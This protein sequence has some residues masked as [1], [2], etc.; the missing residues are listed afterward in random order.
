MINEV[1]GILTSTKPGG[2]GRNTDRLF[3]AGV[4]EVDAN[5][6]NRPREAGDKMWSESGRRGL[7]NC[8]GYVPCLKLVEIR[9]YHYIS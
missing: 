4:G 3:I 8:A 2:N 1:C 5:V 7:Q 6:I 9:H